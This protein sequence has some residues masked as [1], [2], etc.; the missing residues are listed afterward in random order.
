MATEA[1]A[2]LQSRTFRARMSALRFHAAKTNAALQAVE[3]M[4]SAYTAGG[5]HES[6]SEV[7]AC[8][9]KAQ[10]RP[11]WKECRRRVETGDEAEQ[12]WGD[13]EA[14]AAQHDWDAGFGEEPGDYVTEDRKSVV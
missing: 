10:A 12:G 13:C 5:G 9:P 14:Q 11:P 2:I 8:T 3:Q 7:Y 4:L 6:V 1:E